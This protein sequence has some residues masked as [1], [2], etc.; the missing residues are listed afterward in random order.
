MNTHPTVQ[1]KLA[2]AAVRAVCLYS[3]HFW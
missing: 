2:P 3:L 1:G